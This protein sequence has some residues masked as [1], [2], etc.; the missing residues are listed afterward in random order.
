MPA[1]LVWRASKRARVRAERSPFLRSFHDPTEEGRAGAWGLCPRSKFSV[2]I[3]ECEYPYNARSRTT[4]IPLLLCGAGRYNAYI[5]ALV[6]QRLRSSARS[7]GGG[8]SMIQHFNTPPSL[9]VCEYAPNRK[10]EKD[11]A[12]KVSSAADSR[13]FPRYQ[14]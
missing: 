8:L 11:E 13:F 5:G 6:I 2:S 7:H 1:R 9:S 10:E 12:Q 3:S 14:S 4:A